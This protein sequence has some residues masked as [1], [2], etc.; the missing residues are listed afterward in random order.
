MIYLKLDPY[1]LPLYFFLTFVQNLAATVFL[2]P[3]LPCCKK[4]SL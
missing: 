3:A 2:S 4:Q 1:P